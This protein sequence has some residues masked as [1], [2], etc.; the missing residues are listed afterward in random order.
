[1]NAEP[2]R[3]PVDRIIDA[4]AADARPVTPLP[5]PWRR[6]L[7][8]LGLFVLA[9]AIA[10]AFSDV[11]ALLARYGGRELQLAAEMA[12]I[13]A[14]GLVAVTGAFHVAIPGRSRLWLA[15]PVP[16]LLGWLTLSGAGCYR[17]GPIRWEL[18]DSAHCL[19]FI[20][21]TSAALAVPLVWRLSR[22]SP[23]HALPVA[24]LGGLGVAALSAFLLFFYHPFDVTIVDLSVHLAAILL[25][26]GAM[27]LLRRRTLSP[28]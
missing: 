26:T 6:A 9:G 11:G 3:F 1:M 10:I 21:A 12:A 25:V 19:L 28:A 2:T 20:T 24:L 18:G 14:T 7:T 8:T 22:A 13:L 15:A 27:A 16:F 17:A 5:S 23:I 4:L